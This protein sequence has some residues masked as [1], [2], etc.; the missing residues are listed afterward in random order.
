MNRQGTRAAARSAGAWTLIETL[1][2][3]AVV[4]LLVS[5]VLPVLVRELDRVARDVEQ[6]Q[7]GLLAQASRELAKRS[8]E[9]PEPRNFAAWLEVHGPWSRAGIA[10]NARAVRRAVVFDPRWRTGPSQGTSLPWVQTPSGSVEPEATRWMLVSSLGEPL[11]ASVLSDEGVTSAAFDVLWST[12]AGTIPVDWGWTG[13]PEDLVIER[14]DL[15]DEFVPVVLSNPEGRRPGVGLGTNDWIVDPGVTERWYLQGTPLR[16]LDEWGAVQVVERISGPRCWQFSGGKWRQC[17]AW[18]D[19]PGTPSGRDAAELAEA[20]L[21]APVR[22][23]AD[24][25]APAR[26]IGAIGE[27]LFAYEEWMGNGS[28]IPVIEGSRIREAWTS[29]RRATGELMED[30]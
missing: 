9:V 15:R 19:R 26:M 4:A 25:D 22:S 21:R 30:P 7:L 23:G 20:A 27:F 17:G 3:L 11:P 5:L 29:L 12:P 16:L 2:V 10:T 6:R 18:N 13:R 1:G 8:G 24:P 28:P 14:V